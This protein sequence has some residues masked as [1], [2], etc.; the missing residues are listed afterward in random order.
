MTPA[1]RPPD[2][3]ECIEQA[4]FFRVFRDRLSEN[5]PAQEILG[6]LHEELLTT[7]KLPMA[8]QF[9]ASELRHTGL[10]GSGFA[11]LSHYFTPFQAFVVRQSEQEK[12][13]F[14][15][16]A[17]LLV[18]EREATYKASGP[19]PAGLFVYQ[20]ESIARNKLGYDEGLRASAEDPFFDADW[21]A[22]IDLVRRQVGTYDFADLVYVRSEQYLAD[23]RRTNPG[24]EP[25]V[26]PLFGEK[27]G[28]IARAS[29]G[30]DPLF[31]FAAL[32]RQLGYP[33]V[34]RPR[35]KDDINSQMEA[36]RVK[37]REMEARLRMV[38]AEQRGTFDPTQFG[39]PDL[40]K[41]MKDE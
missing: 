25:P 1:A 22:Y 38:E 31:L 6:R 17:A 5:L 9:L 19:T 40:F 3:D 29:R 4:Y 8:V 34:P 36:L 14:A 7:T 27:E 39:K 11:R 12:N 10:L 35:P 32:Q 13:K 37:L 30:R 41:D 24:Y 2:R 21:R 28:K 23:Q 26:P 15:T 20:F 16:T 33:E 18:L